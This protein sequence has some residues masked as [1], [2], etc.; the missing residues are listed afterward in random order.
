MYTDR[1]LLLVIAEP[2]FAQVS[3]YGS[4]DGEGLPQDPDNPDLKLEPRCVGI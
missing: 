2:M 1:H 4:Y 3:L